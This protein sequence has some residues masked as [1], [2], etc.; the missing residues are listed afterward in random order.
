LFVIVTLF[1]NGQNCSAQTMLSNAVY[2]CHLVT[3]FI[4]VSNMQQ[5]FLRT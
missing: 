1:R 2:C 3:V 5:V 4:G